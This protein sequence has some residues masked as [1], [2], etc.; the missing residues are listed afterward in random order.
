MDINL[1]ASRAERFDNWT[2]S[3]DN[4]NKALEGE[5]VEDFQLFDFQAA[6][7][8]KDL[9]QAAQ[10]Y[11]DLYDTDGDGKWDKSEFTRMALGGQEIPKGMEAQY[12]AFFAKTFNALNLDNEEDSINAGEYASM[13]Y[14]SDMNWDNYMK[15]GDLVS[16]L[17]GKID[18]VQYQTYSGLTEGDDG[19]DFLTS[20]RK[21]FYDY[22]YGE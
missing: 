8:S 6:S 13:L 12:E 1:N 11:I 7:Y 15:T 16:S 3:E 14:V 20:Q 9:K 2:N 17:D 4:Y 10:E 18:Y 21:E 5:K 19:Y 22:Y